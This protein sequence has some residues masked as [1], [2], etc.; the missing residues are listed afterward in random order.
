MFTG[1]Y[2]SRH[3]AGV[4]QRRLRADVPT[5]A[6]R[7][8]AAGYVTAGVAGGRLV[9]HHFG[10]GRGFT[11]YLDP[12]DGV[13]TSADRLT[14]HA[15]DLLARSEGEHLFLFLNYF[16]PHWT[17]AAPATYATAAGVPAARA[18]LRSEAWQGAAAGNANQWVRIMHGE[19]APTPQGLA[20]LRAAYEAEVR[21][22]DAEVGRLFAELKR[23][24]AWRDALV[25]VVADHGEL[26]GERGLYSHA[27]RL[28]P[29]L[30]DVP[31][32][33]KWPGQ[34]TPRRPDDLVSV[35]DLFPTLLRAAGLASP[36]GLDGLPLQDAEVSHG[37]V[38]YEE[39]RSR[40]H[41][42]SHPRLLLAPHLWGA[43]NRSRR[44]IVWEGGEECGER[45]AAGWRTAPCEGSRRAFL[46]A[47]QE[48]LGEPPEGGE[49][50]A[51]EV[52][53]EERAVLKALGY[54]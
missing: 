37:R 42:L 34:R 4:E 12:D 15:F 47:V 48:R 1:L 25:V 51:G 46:A 30:V 7:L 38:F 11:Y 39:H 19:E 33:V 23:R 53:E 9:S 28:E 18:V 32:L 40:I 10:A 31:L 29:E 21:F 16:D 13:R 27:Y 6:R 54:L 8:A 14:D 17:Y 35:A 24:G 2:P 50:Q 36:A 5:L 20:W 26:L 49:A 3:G 44:R 41:G 52:N 22:M 43:Q 45:A